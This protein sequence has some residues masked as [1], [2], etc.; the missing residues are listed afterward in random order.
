MSFDAATAELYATT[1]LQEAWGD[2]VPWSD[3]PQFDWPDG[4][5]LI[6]SYSSYTTINDRADGKFYPVFENEQDLAA[7]RGTARRIMALSPFMPASIAA[8][9]VY[10]MG[11]GPAISVTGRGRQPKPDENTRLLQ[12][13][14]DRVTEQ[15]ELP[16][17][18]EELH[19]RSREEGES[20][21]ILHC[22]G[23]CLASEIVEMDCLTEPVASSQL[24]DWI[25]DEFNIDCEA[26]VPSWSFGVLTPKRATNKPL[27]YH[28]VYESSGADFEFY[29]ASR[30]IHLKRNVP[31]NVK[32]G[33]SDWYQDFDDLRNEAKVAKNIGV[34]TALQA[35]IA[36]IE[37]YSAGTTQAQAQNTT[38]TDL[39]KQI[40][41]GIGQG[42]GTRNQR[43]THYPPGTIVRTSAGRQ[44]KPGPLGAERN[45][46]FEIAV[47]MLLRRVGIRHQMPEYMISGDASNANFASTMVA[48]SPF[49]KAREAD[50]EYMRRVTVSLLW[51]AI[52]LVWTAWTDKPL[53]VL[54]QLKFGYEI[55]VEFPSVQ[56][57]DKRA[58]AEQLEVEK[59]NGW[60]SDQTAMSELGRDPEQE[61]AQGAK[62]AL[63]APSPFGGMFGQSGQDQTHD[64]PQHRPPQGQKSVDDLSPTQVAALQGALESVETTA[65]ARSVLEAMQRSYP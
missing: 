59:R 20:L 52:A 13:V 30:V 49:V 55:K 38:P 37:E 65:E 56:T 32:R 58:L 45:G 9:R 53:E 43:G 4:S 25:R 29:P 39:L 11:N 48:E 12:W 51:K 47:Q 21:D 33:V 63:P 36:W 34:N 50:Q 17:L 62:Q 41:T 6:R 61:K 5:S 60:V 31:A 10:T 46:N 18:L 19:D 2:V 23:D 8:L 15:L 35:A 42:G 7:I 1:P 26:F 24:Q 57:R 44:Y 16:Q 54:E 64:Q 27:G 28:V 3:Y 40:P 22:H 14:I